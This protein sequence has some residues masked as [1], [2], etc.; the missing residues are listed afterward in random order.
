MTDKTLVLRPIQRTLVLYPKGRPGE[1]GEPGD[2]G[3]G[4]DLNYVFSQSS[5]ASTWTITHPLNKFPSVSVIDSSGRL[6]YGVVNYD[7]TSQVTVDF[8]GR[9]F[10]GKAYLN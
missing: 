3:S 7:S 2:G 5:P 1:K 4:G 9:S 6:V 10:S 8:N